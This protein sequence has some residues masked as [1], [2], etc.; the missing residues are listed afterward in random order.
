MI[1][2]KLAYLYSKPVNFENFYLLIKWARL[3]PGK[4]LQVD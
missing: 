3:W 1:I 4:K 2:A